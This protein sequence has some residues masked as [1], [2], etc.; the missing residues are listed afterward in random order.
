MAYGLH[1]TN[2][3]GDLLVSSDIKS[4]HY[5]GSPTYTGVQSSYDNYSGSRIYRY[6]FTDSQT[7][8]I[9]KGGESRK[10]TGEGGR[11]SVR[12]PSSM[13]TLVVGDRT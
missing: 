12:C 9:F 10:P 11:P 1:I 13:E 5:V 2:T 7:P 3:S 8:L 6:T 4:Y